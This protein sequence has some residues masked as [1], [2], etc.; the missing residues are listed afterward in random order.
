MAASDHLSQHQFSASDQARHMTVH[1]ID[2]SGDAAKD[3]EAHAGSH[4]SFHWEGHSHQDAGPWEGGPT[5]I[6]TNSY[7]RAG[8]V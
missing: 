6:S 8:H 2:Y 7:P 5:G 1:G 4:S 3:Q